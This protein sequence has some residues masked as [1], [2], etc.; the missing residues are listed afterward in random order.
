MTTMLM[1]LGWV[2]ANPGSAAS[3]LMGV[4]SVASAMFEMCGMTKTSKA[5][6]TL[7]VVDGGR[8]TRY[9][10]LFLSLLKAVG[11]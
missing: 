10:K 7:P 5:I 2:I 6:G 1:I 8:I 3:I 11:K 9:A 4:L